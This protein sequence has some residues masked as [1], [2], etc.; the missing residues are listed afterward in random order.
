MTPDILTLAASVV[1]LP[2]WRWIPGMLL[3][4]GYRVVGSADYGD[5][6]W[7]LA[8][9]GGAT[10]TNVNGEGWRRILG[11]EEGEMKESADAPLPDLTDA[12]TGGGLLSLLGYERGCIYPWAEGYR[13]RI[14]IKAP[15]EPPCATLAEACARVALA[16]G[17]WA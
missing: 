14:T 4:D 5:G 10:L 7:A 13:W 3:A 2:G 9:S 8:L 17:R 12:A 6:M 15:L 16:R 11:E 1:A